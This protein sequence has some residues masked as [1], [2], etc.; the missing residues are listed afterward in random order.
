MYVGMTNNLERRIAEHLSGEV[1]GFAQRYHLQTLVH[2]EMFDRVDDAITREKQIKGWSRAKK[3]ALV[4]QHNRS[5]ADL[6]KG[7]YGKDSSLRSE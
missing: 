5:W 2:A 4:Q 1:K 3:N 7:H 6:A